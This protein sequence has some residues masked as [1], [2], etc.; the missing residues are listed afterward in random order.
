M[1]KDFSGKHYQILEE[2][3]TKL[4]AYDAGTKTRVVYSLTVPTYFERV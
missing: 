4:I 2:T 3:S 1:I